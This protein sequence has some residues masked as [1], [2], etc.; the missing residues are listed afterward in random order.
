MFPL[1]AGAIGI[2]GATAFEFDMSFEPPSCLY[3]PCGS[4]GPGA[5]GFLVDPNALYVQFAAGGVPP[6][7]VTF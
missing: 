3:V 6:N 2:I 5:S 1:I 4:L 7:H